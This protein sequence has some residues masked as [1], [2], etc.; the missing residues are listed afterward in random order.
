MSLPSIDTH[1]FCRRADT[2]RGTEPLSALGRVVSLLADPQGD[3][4]W[5][6]TGRSAVREVQLPGLPVIPGTRVAVHGHPALCAL[7]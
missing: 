2:A 3:V 7:P 1:E 4:S 5:Q 6:L